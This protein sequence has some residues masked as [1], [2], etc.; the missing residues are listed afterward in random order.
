MDTP[1][2]CAPQRLRLRGGDLNESLAVHEDF[3]RPNLSLRRHQTRCP[4][5]PQ[6]RC[7]CY[8][9]SRAIS[10]QAITMSRRSI[11]P[12]RI[13]TRFRPTARNS[14]AKNMSHC[15]TS[16]MCVDREVAWFFPYCYLRKRTVASLE[17]VMVPA[18]HTRYV[19]RDRPVS[20]V[21]SG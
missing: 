7:L 18:S 17:Q 19:Y 1:A 21:G 9:A 20:P 12:D 11:L 2:A 8:E 15:S 3:D 13:Y 5:A 4:V 16:A 6:A 14:R 10:P